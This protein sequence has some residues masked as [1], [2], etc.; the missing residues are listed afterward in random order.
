MLVPIGINLEDLHC[1]QV[2]EDHDL[3][4]HFATH[5][6]L[7]VS[8]CFVAEEKIIRDAQRRLMHQM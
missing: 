7:V 5:L 6:A 8:G 2:P 3:L 4:P 1:A